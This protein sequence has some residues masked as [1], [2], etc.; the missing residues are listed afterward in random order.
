MTRGAGLSWAAAAQQFSVDGLS[1]SAEELIDVG[2]LLALAERV[3]IY[4]LGSDREA[5]ELLRRYLR[6]LGYCV[7]ADSGDAFHTGTAWDTVVVFV[8]PP[9]AADPTPLDLLTATGAVLLAI[10]PAKAAQVAALADAVVTLPIPAPSKPGALPSMVLDLL[11]SM[12]VEALHRDL[13]ARLNHGVLSTPT[14][15]PGPGS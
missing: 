14:S 2:S 7:A 13:T 1:L 3:H 6:G 9:T 4:S 12:V 11:T 10:A 15:Q 8:G 5:P